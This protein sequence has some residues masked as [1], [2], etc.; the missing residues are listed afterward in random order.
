MF[1]TPITNEYKLTEKIVLLESN[2]VHFT[3]YMQN[4]NLLNNNKANGI[5]QNNKLQTM[6]F[7]I[8]QKGIIMFFIYLKFIFDSNTK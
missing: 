2:N 5:N 4:K 8:C 1:C 3:N 6:D 7:G